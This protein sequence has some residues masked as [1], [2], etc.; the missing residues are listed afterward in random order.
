MKPK[1]RLFYYAFLCGFGHNNDT[2]VYSLWWAIES[3]Y[4]NA[5]DYGI[6]LTRKDLLEFALDRLILRRE[7]ET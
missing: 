7:D 2:E 3:W 4:K 5:H 6:G 1:Y